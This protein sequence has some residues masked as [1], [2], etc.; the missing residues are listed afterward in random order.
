MSLRVI[1]TVRAPIPIPARIV[2]FLTI[3][4][5]KERAGDHPA[6][7]AV[8]LSMPPTPTTVARPVSC[9]L[10]RVPASVIEAVLLPFL[11]SKGWQVQHN[12]DGAWAAVSD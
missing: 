3:V 6:D 7:A 11:G 9:D 4:L 5:N 1:W 2:G 8:S 10:A 12:G